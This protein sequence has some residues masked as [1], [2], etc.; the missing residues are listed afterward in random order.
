M[1]AVLSRVFARYG[2]SGPIIRTHEIPAL[3]LAAALSFVLVYG[4]LGGLI[5]WDASAIRPIYLSGAMLWLCGAAFEIIG[6]KRLGR[7]LRLTALF[8]ILALST[9]WA[10]NVLAVVSLPYGDQSLADMDRWLGVD[11]PAMVTS[12]QTQPAVLHMLSYAYA[13]LDGQPLLLLVLLCIFRR[14]DQA[15]RFLTAWGLALACC[16]IV[17]PFCPAVG[18]YAHFHIPPKAVPDVLSGE[19]WQYP[20]LLEQ[21]RS[22][23]ITRLNTATLGGII[24]MPSFHAASA[25]LLAWGFWS[26]RWL[27]WPLLL[28]NL[29]MLFST[30]PIGGHYLVDVLAG[31]LVA[32]VSILVGEKWI[33]AMSRSRRD[34]TSEQ[35][36]ARDIPSAL[37]L[38]PCEQPQ[39]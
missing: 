3:L 24:A 37:A 10:S 11:W 4:V 22:G 38:Q 19:P 35:P 15:W 8:A 31:L 12:L 27:R 18:G 17:F 28:L 2:V 23:A 26:L 33:G 14:D 30:I 21:L 5:D 13:S 7:C 25:L 16:L 39:Q 20:V 36:L 1:N 29:A 6:G 9:A 32:A 34:A